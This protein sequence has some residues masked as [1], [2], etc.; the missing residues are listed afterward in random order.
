MHFVIGIHVW[1]WDVD[2]TANVLYN[3]TKDNKHYP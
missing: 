3:M 2:V 1:Q